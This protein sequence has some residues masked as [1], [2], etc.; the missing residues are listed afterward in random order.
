MS[1]DLDAFMRRHEHLTGDARIDTLHEEFYALLQ[2]LREAPRE[3]AADALLALITHTREHFAHEDDEMT[4]GNYPIREC[5]IDEHAEVMTSLVQ[6]HE[7]LC[8]DDHSALP[9]LVQALE[10]WFPGH[11]QHLDSAL[12]QW[13]VKRRHNAQPIMLRRHAASPG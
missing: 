2:A 5:H 6:V 13:L 7:R 8:Q 10:D 4:S 12:A 3:Q 1:H 11:V 9:R